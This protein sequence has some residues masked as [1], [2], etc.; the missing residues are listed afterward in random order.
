ME[1]DTA[2]HASRAI[3]GVHSL[4]MAHAEGFLVHE[5]DV[6]VAQFQHQ[7]VTRFE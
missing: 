6:E 5:L 2:E 3:L 1:L 4:E 7:M